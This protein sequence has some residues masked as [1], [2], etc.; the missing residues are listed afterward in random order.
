MSVRRVS[1]RRA[2]TLVELLVVIAIIGVLVGLLLPAV[3]A[4][5]EAARRMSCQSNLRQLGIALHNHHDTYGYFPDG[6]DAIDEHHEPGW[7]W[8]AGLLPFMEQQPGHDLINFNEPIETPEHSPV[9]TMTVSNFMCPSDIGP[10]IFAIAEGDGLH[11]HGHG[12]SGIGSL[13]DD[14]H[15]DHDHEHGPSH[16]DE[17]L[18]PL[19]EIAKCNYSGVFGTFDLHEN[20]FKGDGLFY[21]NS[22]LRMRDIVDGTS[23]TLMVGE[24]SSRLGGTI[25]H[26][27]IPEANEFEARIVGVTD[28]TPNHPVGHFEDFS[29]YHRGVTG[30]VMGDGSV[31]HLSD[32]I[33]LAVYKALATRQGSE[34]VD[35]TKY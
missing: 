12:H 5:R 13:E 2:F 24:R 32:N 30:F 6:W 28:H 33:D 35:S 31:R 20:P 29:S 19:F 16:A 11:G 15:D 22:Q 1:A 17:G 8:A 18:H 10:S 27:A 3:Q 21:A 34:V 9:R 26:G 14:D 23:T 7:G 25:W 4:A